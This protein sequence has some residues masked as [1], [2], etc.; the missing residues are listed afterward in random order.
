M[1]FCIPYMDD[2]WLVGCTEGWHITMSGILNGRFFGNLIMN[3][4]VRFKIPKT[5][6]MSIVIWFIP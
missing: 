2:D 4:L 5:I 3:I 1:A 6:I